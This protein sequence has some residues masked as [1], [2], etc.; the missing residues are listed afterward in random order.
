MK[1]LILTTIVYDMP[2]QTDLVTR[3]KLVVINSSKTAD[4]NHDTEAAVAAA[5]AWFEK[6]VM[7]E[8]G[9]TYISITAEA[10][11]DADN[12][13]PQALYTEA[14]LVSFGNFMAQKILALELEDY[15]KTSAEYISKLCVW[16]SDLAN[17]REENQQQTKWRSRK[18]HPATDRLVECRITDDHAVGS[19]FARAK[20]MG[21]GIE[22]F[23][24]N[25]DP[26][27]DNLKFEWTEIKRNN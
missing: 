21:H 15:D 19:F 2:G 20:F 24:D 27:Y 16:D 17:W 13:E 14:D 4:E 6:S 5:K 7:A 8:Q 25:G 1:K 12:P 11:I 10:T 18:Q 23:Y 26:V 22:W 3:Q 9:A